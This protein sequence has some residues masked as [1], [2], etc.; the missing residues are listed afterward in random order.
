M[1]NGNVSFSEGLH[2]LAGSYHLPVIQ[3]EFTD[4]YCVPKTVGRAGDS[5]V[6]MSDKQKPYFRFVPRWLFVAIKSTMT[7][8]KQFTEG[9]DYLAYTSRS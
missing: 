5:M 4:L 1:F 6:N 2:F 9:R 7:T 8:H 3:Q